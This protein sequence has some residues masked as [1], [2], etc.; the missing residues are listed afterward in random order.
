MSDDGNATLVGKANRLTSVPG[1]H[2]IRDAQTRSLS[3]ASVAGSRRPGAAVIIAG[4]IA[5]GVAGYLIATHLVH[6]KDAP[7]AAAAVNP[8]GSDVGA[9]GSGPVPSAPPLVIA[10]VAV[11]VDG[12]VWVFGA[13][14]VP[15]VVPPL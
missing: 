10:R 13:A 5:V 4:A 3:V 9:H 2:P 12:I 15:T 11:V 1:D 6:G 8:A 14:P 7:V